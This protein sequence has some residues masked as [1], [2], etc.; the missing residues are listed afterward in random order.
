[1][2]GDP[3]CRTD[4]GKCANDKLKCAGMECS[5]EEGFMLILADVRCI[6]QN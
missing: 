6:A 5:M 4:T 2:S 1:M 3:E